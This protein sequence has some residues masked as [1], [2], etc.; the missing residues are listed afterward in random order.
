MPAVLRR[1]NEIRKPVGNKI[2]NDSRNQGRL[3]ELSLPEFRDATQ[4]SDEQYEQVIGMIE[5][6]L[7]W[8]EDPEPLMKDG[9]RALSLHDEIV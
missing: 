6:G 9:I 7:K 3:F 2:L 5:A 1:Y 4:L 8:G